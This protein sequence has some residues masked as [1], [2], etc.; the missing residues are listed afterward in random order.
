[1]QYFLHVDVLETQW[2]V[3]QKQL[4]R[5]SDYD[6]LKKAHSRF[7]T[8]IRRQCFLDAKTIRRT[9]DSVF[10]LCVT[11]CNL[12]EKHEKDLTKVKQIDIDR[13]DSEYTRHSNYLFLVLSGIS[14]SLKMRL[15]YNGTFTSVTNDLEQA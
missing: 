1:M 12:V 14:P 10:R 5:V 11:L 13:I 6:S 8:S 9:L 15:D 3:L 7:V 2:H 4:A